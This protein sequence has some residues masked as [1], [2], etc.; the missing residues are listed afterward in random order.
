MN[1]DDSILYFPILMAVETASRS[2]GTVALSLKVAYCS[3]A[4][5][6]GFNFMPSR[7]RF[8]ASAR[9]AITP[10]WVAT[11]IVLLCRRPAL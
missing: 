10:Y 1:A 2:V 5:R 11:L 4:N 9:S 3:E 8:A 6:F 7:T